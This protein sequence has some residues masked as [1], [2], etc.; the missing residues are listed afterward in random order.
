FRTGAESV[1]NTH[2]EPF[3]NNFPG[4][5]SE[6]IGEHSWLFIRTTYA[7]QL[8]APWSEWTDRTA[9]ATNKGDCRTRLLTSKEPIFKG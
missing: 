8:N 6:T 2:E 9:V 7:D 3:R 1:N 4:N 5:G